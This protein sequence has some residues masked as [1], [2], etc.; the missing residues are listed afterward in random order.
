VIRT[1]RGATLALGAAVAVALWPAPA[2]AHP[3]GNF[4]VNTAAAILLS[5]GSVQVRYVVDMAEIPTVQTLPMIDA[6]GDGRATA[7]EL[8]GWADAEARE[9]IAG[10]HVEVDGGTVAL[11]V[12]SAAAELRP[13]QGGLEVLR[14]DAGLAGDVSAGGTLT[15]RDGNFDGRVGWHEVTA[16]GIDGVEVRGST[17]PRASATDGLRVYP[18]DLLASPLDVRE[19]SLSF[20]PGTGVAE[21]GSQGPEPAGSPANAADGDLAGGGLAGLV[22]RSG[23]MMV[24]ALFLAFAFGALH[25]LGPGHGKT[26]MAVYLVGGR[27][28]VRQAAAVGAAVA[29]MHTAS[30]LALGLVVLGATEVFAPERVYPWL[31]LASGLIA[32]GLGAGLLVSRLGA[33]GTSEPHEHGEGGAHGHHAHDHADD[34]APLLSRRGLAALAVAGGILPSPTALVVLL[35]SVALHRVGYGLALIGAFSLG[36]A[37]AL[38]AVGILALAAH[39][40]VERHLSSRFAR[41]MPVAS[42][43]TIAMLG[44]VLT[45]N[46]V[47]RL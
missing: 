2:F 7:S 24:V 29:V 10:L 8:D 33:W 13:G 5:P 42:A 36:L 44:L 39:A 47:A 40:S 15:F 11:R 45:L 41:A 16:T 32:L 6:D 4:T 22:D 18:E 19:A 34:R 26:L 38:V 30:V 14:L 3:L 46:G 12:T 43:G 23:P 31:G 1:L 28:R 9:L 25:A 21:A 17:V 27:G 20:A 35:G 37:A